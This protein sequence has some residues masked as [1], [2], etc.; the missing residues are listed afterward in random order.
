MTGALPAAASVREPST[1]DASMLPGTD[2]RSVGFCCVGLGSL[3]RPGCDPC[4][5]A[6][7]FWRI[8]DVDG[9][10]LASLII[11]PCNVS[12]QC[13]RCLS[14]ACAPLTLA[15][16]VSAGRASRLWA[17]LLPRAARCGRQLSSAS[18]PG[19]LPTLAAAR[20][21]GMAARSLV[22]ALLVASRLPCRHPCALR[23]AM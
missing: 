5:A 7:S 15:L 23:E 20:A 10:Q 13:D 21:F 3:L 11:H 14:L 19:Q 6:D 18:I 9:L 8:A 12:L 22:C 4:S 16:G 17:K 1:S 2:L